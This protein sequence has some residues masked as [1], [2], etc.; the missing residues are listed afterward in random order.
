[1]KTT[2]IYTLFALLM[3]GVVRMQAQEPQLF[4]SAPTNNSL[5]KSMIFINDDEVL[6]KIGKTVEG[7]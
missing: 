2:R 7:R 4:Y 3:M 6:V 1:M 5:S